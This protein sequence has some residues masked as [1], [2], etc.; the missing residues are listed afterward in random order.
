MQ[1]FLSDFL[2]HETKES[3]LFPVQ[4]EAIGYN[5]M[6]KS[7]TFK[8]STLVRQFIASLIYLDELFVCQVPKQRHKRAY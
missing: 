5:K 7:T 3:S 2:A 6:N 4:F 8:A 1:Y